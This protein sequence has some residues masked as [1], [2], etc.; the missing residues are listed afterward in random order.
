MQLSN[1]QE[2]LIENWQRAFPLVPQPYET[3]G[4][5][6]GATECDVIHAL[7]DLQLRGILSASAPQSGPIRQAQARWP[8]CRSLSMIFQG[9]LESST[10]KRA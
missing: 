9:S 2:R 8:R 1:L 3:I 5:A 7:R 10:R 6:L 4:A